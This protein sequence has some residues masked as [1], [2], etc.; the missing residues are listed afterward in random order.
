LAGEYTSCLISAQLLSVPQ[1]S[2]ATS[3]TATGRPLLPACS[4][5]GLVDQRAEG[6][7]PG[8][9]LRGGQPPD[10]KPQSLK[11]SYRTPRQLK[12]YPRLG[13]IPSHS[14]TLIIGPMVP[15]RPSQASGGTEDTHQIGAGCRENL[16]VVC[17]W[18]K[19]ESGELLL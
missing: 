13:I 14:S 5:E 11:K 8:L 1:T 16:Q 17:M 19:Q 12:V 7:E 2:R 15:Q 6:K 10:F 3:K 4:R 18:P 9:P